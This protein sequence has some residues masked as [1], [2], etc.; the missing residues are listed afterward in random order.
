M[1]AGLIRF[2]TERPRTVYALIWALVLATAALIP[3]IQ[4]DTDPENMLPSDDPARVFHNQVKSDFALYDSMVVGAVAENGIFNPQSLATMHQLTDAILKLEPVV[5]A[6]LM[7]LSTSD[8]ITQE[9]PGTIRFEYLMKDAPQTQAAS[10]AIGDAVARLPLLNNTL[11]SGDGKAA[12]IYV[13]LYNKDDSYQVAESIRALIAE[14]DPQ[15]TYYLTGLPVAENQFGHEMFVQMAVSAPLAGAMIFALMWFFFRS[16]PL[17]IAPMLVA[18]ATVIATMGTLIGMGYTVHIMSSMIAIF[19]MPIAVVDSVH[20]MS[21][22]T[23]RYRAGKDAKAV[24]REVMGDLF[25]PMLFTSVTSAVG[26]YSLM[27]TPIPP[28]QVFGAFVGSGILLAF[29]LSVLLVPAYVVRMKPATLDKMQARLHG[30]AEHSGLLARFL[31]R[32]GRFSVRQAKPIVIVALLIL[33]FS[34]VGI[35]KIQINDNPVRW[36]KADH[37]IRIAD[38]ALNEHFAGTYDAYLVLTDD[39]PLI[40]TETKRQLQA[41]LAKALP[42]DAEAEAMLNQAD[43]QSLASLLSR[44]DDAAFDADSDAQIDAIDALMPKLETVTE[45]SRRFLDPALLAW[46]A[47]L[48]ADLNDS[49]LVGKS[50]ALPDIVKTVNRELHS[51]EDKDFAL[52]DSAAGVAQTLLQFQSSHR[53]QDLWHFVSRDY[54]QGLIWLQ[55]TSGD[56]QHMNG[57]IAHVDQYLSQH[58]LPQGLSADWAGKAYINVIWQDAMVTGMM[59]SLLSAFVVIFIMMSLLF[60]SPLY[61]LIAMLPLSLTIAFIYGLV[62]WLGKDY[63]MPIAVLSALALGLS[64]DFAIHFLE[65][66][67]AIHKETG[68]VRQTLAMMFEE[69]AR[70]ISRNA[71]VIALG[72]TPLLM[73]PLVPY[74]TVGVLMASIMAVSATV[75]L[76]LLP[77]AL[78]LFSRWTL[79][80][81][82]APETSSQPTTGGTHA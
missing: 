12:A 52:P 11:V 56:N 16:I 39:R 72:F 43:G 1:K 49:G 80:E 77:A 22:F 55:L 82:K 7:A 63:D 44:L 51:G 8:N 78:S 81:P 47:D 14:L 54:R 33:G 28:V 4:I 40:D 3:N 68:S 26:F 9:G 62:G 34:A 24:I 48:Q 66:T 29:I 23:D 69:P 15:D 21:D 58:P 5:K 61:G 18:M 64:V 71:I 76:L 42:G 32:A 31:P 67:R 73:A 70:A 65:R 27:L 38:K 13:P 45:Q 25:N 10:E 74:I 35:S 75:T 20:I 37:E 60:R 30:H 79:P 6:D 46:M 36:F 2:A 53:P 17:V 59:E 50:N 57:V 19:L 41:L